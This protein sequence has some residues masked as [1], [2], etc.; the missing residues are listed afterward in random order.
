LSHHPEQSGH[1]VQ[2][3][4]ILEDMF[5]SLIFSTTL[6]SCRSS[7][8]PFAHTGM[9]TSDIGEV[10]EPNPGCSGSTGAARGAMVPQNF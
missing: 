7:H 3:V 4:G 9:E 5:G 6:A 1:A 2:E 10:V 8:I